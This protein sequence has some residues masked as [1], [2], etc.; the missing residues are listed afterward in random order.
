MSLN[1]I[2][3]LS[4]SRANTESWASDIS[5]SNTV[6]E[7]NSTIGSLSNLSI[8]N[9]S[10]SRDDKIYLQ[11]KQRRGSNTGL[12]KSNDVS[13]QPAKLTYLTSFGGKVNFPLVEDVTMI[14]RR[15]DNQIQLKKCPKISKYHAAIEK[16]D[17]RYY[18][19]DKKSSNG[20]KLNSHYIE[21]DHPQLLS[22]GDKILIGSVQLEFFDEVSKRPSL[23]DDSN[24]KLVTILPS[25]QKY[26]ETITTKVEIEADE[27]DFKK[28]GEVDSVSVLREDYEKLRLAY[29][30]SKFSLGDDITSLLAKSLDMMFEILPVDRGVVLLVDQTT[31]FLASH[32]VKLR[33]GKH[34]EGRE[35]L[36][37]STIIHRV[38][39]SRVCLITSDACED[40]LLGKAAS[41]KYGQI[42][43]VICVPLVAHN[44]VHGILHLDSR[45]RYNFSAKDLSLVKAISNQTAMAIE[46]S[47]LIKEVENKARITEQ[48]SRFLAPHVV[49]KMVNKNEIIR[50][51]GREITGTIVFTDI[52]GF[53]NISEQARGP[54]E[55][56]ELL[57]EFFER[58]VRV[59][60]KHEGVVDKYIGDCLMAVF[61]SIED[62]VDSEFRA[63]QACL[64]FNE[65][66][67]EMNVDRIRLG[68]KPI[69]I[70][71]GV[72][73]GNLVAG[74]IGCSQR[75]E[76]TC[77]GDSVNT[78]ARMC[79]D[80]TCGQ[81][82]LSEF[83]YEYVKDRVNCRVIGKK[84]YKGKLNEVL[85]YEALSL[86]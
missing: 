59:V 33:A 85:V 23:S 77:I 63:V 72:N 27:V 53:T 15:D 4:R 40:P 9:T 67:K 73:T 76:Y 28:V 13:K 43:S 37:S 6:N 32:Y 83:T 25:E 17:G 46:N 48:L 79:Q 47:I 14:G 68:L 11:T 30:L 19:R 42:R 24:L 39:Q 86:K 81:V 66:M 44:K 34:N 5:Y 84:Q 7:R 65:E 58:I 8:S 55:V 12:N 10:P 75:L 41:V 31:G 60:F 62:E 22:D 26:E 18:I 64:E 80:A 52:R 29:E 57:N 45:D 74:F 21:P 71:T 20:V 36:L 70:G 51:G 1:D 38:Y 82:L 2:P 35:I 54:S 61:G 16:M 49:D 78:S 56:V 69:E 3:K 50:K